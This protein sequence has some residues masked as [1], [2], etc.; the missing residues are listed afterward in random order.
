MRLRVLLACAVALAAG[1]PAASSAEH[2]SDIPTYQRYVALGDSYAAGPGIPEQTGGG[3]GRSTANYP[4]LLA[5]WLE[6]PTFVDVSCGGAVTADLRAAQRL[7]QGTAEPQFAALTA[8]TDLVTL[9]VGGNDVG[10]GEVLA[11]CAREGSADPAG[12]RCRRRYTASGSDLLAAR[13][14]KAGQDVVAALRTIHQRA[15]DAEVVVVGYPRI[16]PAGA[17][18]W[19][20]VPF[21]AGDTAYFDA[22]Q[23]LLNSTLAAAAAENGDTFVDPYPYAEGRDACAPPVRRWVEPLRP[24]SPASPV[25]PNAAGMAAVAALAWLAATR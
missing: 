15:P 16:L 1:T 24:A 11:T 10:F 23:R 21:A 25:H 13:V 18:C 12:D 22:T 5:E 7:G 17:G 14:A 4:A 3:C 20:L 6:V 19:P 8:D 2:V 9:T